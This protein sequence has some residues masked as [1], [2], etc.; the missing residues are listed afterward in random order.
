MSY[1]YRVLVYYYAYFKDFVQDTAILVTKTADTNSVASFFQIAEAEYE[2]VC[3]LFGLPFNFI[4]AA[5]QMK[6]KKL[7]EHVHIYGRN[8][9]EQDVNKALEKNSEFLTGYEQNVINP[10]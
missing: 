8:R 2:V 3:K 6:V 7:P 9:D 4:V 1:S 10:P 5:M